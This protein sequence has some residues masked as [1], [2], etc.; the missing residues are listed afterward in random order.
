MN[1]TEKKKNSNIKQHKKKYCHKISNKNE[2]NNNL[3]II[4]NE[5]SS[6]EFKRESKDSSKFIKN[7]YNEKSYES[8]KTKSL[9]SHNKT[10]KSNKSITD[11]KI[12]RLNIQKK[13]N[14]H[15]QFQISKRVNNISIFPQKENKINFYQYNQNMNIGN[16]IS[17]E[18][19]INHGK[20]NERKLEVNTTNHIL[21]NNNKNSTTNGFKKEDM[22]KNDDNE[23]NNI[24]QNKLN[25][26]KEENINELM[27]SKNNII[28]SNNISKRRSCFCCL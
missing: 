16:F 17:I 26:N 11:I 13:V 10:L 28:K 19:N 9:I 5:E 3:L 4:N 25:E 6:S 27:N 7:N 18:Y 2:F 23:T 8:N 12:K 24:F 1:L 14:I 21:L 15:S 20:K 22:I